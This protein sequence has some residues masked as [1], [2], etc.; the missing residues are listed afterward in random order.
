M[1]NTAAIAASPTLG[2]PFG[3]PLVPC[4]PD[5]TEPR[6]V[7]VLG[8]Y[9]KPLRVRWTPPYGDPV[10]ALP[11][12]TEPVPFWDGADAALC[13]RRWRREV[14]FVPEWGRADPSPANGADGRWLAAHVLSPLGL[15][16][17]DCWGA[18][19]VPYVALPMRALRDVDDV[20]YDFARGAEL[21][22]RKPYLLQRGRRRALSASRDAAPRLDDLLAK[23]DPELVV[24]V[25]S[26]AEWVFFGYAVNLA[27]EA[28]ERLD[29]EHDGPVVSLRIGERRL[30]WVTL[31]R[32]DR[33]ALTRRVMA[34]ASLRLG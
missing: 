17:A 12:D 10:D 25:G 21:P 3:R 31:S 15:A 28:G 11:V 30:R 13:V 33:P 7:L 23:A 1:Q 18:Y 26:F 9:P 16:A 2:F 29:C 4:E 32:H 6:P 24:T 27:V 20:F 5:V 19:A 8:G 14:G 34:D 22:Q